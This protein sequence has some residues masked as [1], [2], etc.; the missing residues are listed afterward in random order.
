MRK[1]YLKILLL[2]ILGV[3][4]NAQSD[5]YA[6]ANIDASIKENA[7]AVIR[8]KQKNIA[9]SSRKSMAIT[10]KNVVTIFNEKGLP[11]TGASEYFDKSTKVKS[12]EAVVL[13]A[14]GK[15]IKRIKRKDFKETSVSEGSMITDNKII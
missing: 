10:S 13:N 12:I 14:S 4:A 5:N 8:L 7:N 15:E 1:N 11:S 3:S 2:L 9:I 6:V